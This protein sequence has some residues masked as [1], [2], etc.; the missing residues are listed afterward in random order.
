M[1][2]LS[3]PNLNPNRAPATYVDSATPLEDRAYREV[4]AAHLMAQHLLDLTQFHDLRLQS[5]HCVLLHRASE[6]G[7]SGGS[8]CT[9]GEGAEP[10]E[11]G[12]S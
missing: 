8:A 7:D 1:S 2:P 12:S 6:K 5:T 11:R 3:S 9:P 10:Q 4:E